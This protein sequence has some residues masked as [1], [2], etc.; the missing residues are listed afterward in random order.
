MKY[1]IFIL[2]VISI[3]FLACSA[4]NAN[5]S[6][7]KYYGRYFVSS[8]STCEITDFTEESLVLLSKMDITIS[9]TLLIIF[10]DTCNYPNYIEVFNCDSDSLLTLNRIHNKVFINDEKVNLVFLKCI[11]DV[12]YYNDESPSFKHVFIYDSQNFYILFRGAMFKLY[13]T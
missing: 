9:D 3:I 11:Q 8:Y 1:L 4:K 10:G 5:P 7:N 6:S 2:G 12:K 13:K